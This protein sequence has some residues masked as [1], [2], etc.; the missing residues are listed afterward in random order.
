MGP[1]LCHGSSTPRLPCSLLVVT[2]HGSSHQPRK[3]ELWSLCFVEDRRYWPASAP[4]SWSEQMQAKC[5]YVEVA[6]SEAHHTAK[7]NWLG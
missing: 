7:P 2:P 3:A 4:G 6:V 5:F 1:G